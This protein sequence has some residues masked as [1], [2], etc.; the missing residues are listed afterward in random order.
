MYRCTEC[1]AE[2][3]ECPDFCDCG[4]D[5]FEEIFE[6]E[7]YE[8]PVQVHVSAPKLKPKRR[9]KRVLT[10]DEIEEM[11]MESLDKKKALVVICISIFISLVILFCPPYP[12]KKI[13]KT[14]ENITVSKANL[15]DVNSYWDNALPAAF[16]KGDTDANIPLLNSS[17]SSISYELRTY[18]VNI[19]EEFFSQWNSSLVEGAGEAVIQFTINRDGIIENKKLVSKSRNESLDNSVL[20]MLSKI[21]NLDVPPEDYKGERIMLAFK[22][23]EKSGNKIYY[24]SPKTK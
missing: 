12:K 11:N 10:E 19:G 9:Q 18:L 13:E 5:T 14:K 6:E 21:T 8:G 15:P 22:T 7:E 3:I 23:D 4:N 16:R 24:P 20:L 2:F 17:F 1:E